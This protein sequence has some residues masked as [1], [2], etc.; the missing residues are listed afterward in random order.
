MLKVDDS[1]CERIADVVMREQEVMFKSFTERENALE[2]QIKKL[3]KEVENAYQAI[4]NAPALAER[5]EAIILENQEEIEKLEVEKAE[6]S[7]GSEWLTRDMILFYFKTLRDMKAPQ[8]MADC[9]VTRVV[10]DQS[11]EP[12][13]VYF[14]FS[15]DKKTNPSVK[16]EEFVLVVNGSPYQI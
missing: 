8:V 1:L 13:K 14:E 6:V 2:A 15:F 3:E 10:I 5:F 12:T 4:L 11:V 9:M 16:P 7:F